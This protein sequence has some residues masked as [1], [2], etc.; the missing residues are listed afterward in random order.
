MRRIYPSFFYDFRCKAQNC[1]HTC[2]RGWDVEIDEASFQSYRDEPGAFGERLRAAI[3]TQDGVHFFRLRDDGRCPMLLD[4]G[5]C[6][7]IVNLG[8]DRLCDIC[9]LHPRFYEEIGDTEL[10]GLGLSC[11]AAAELLLARPL[12]F[13]I[14]EEQE[15]EK[16]KETDFRRLLDRLGLDFPTELLAFSPELTAEELDVLKNALYDDDPFDGEW[17]AKVG[18]LALPAGKDKRKTPPDYGD[19]YHYFMYRQ[20]ERLFEGDVSPEIAAAYAGALTRYVYLRD[21]QTPDTVR[22]LTE[23][24]EEVEYSTSQVDRIF[25]YYESR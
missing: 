6:E 23:V 10:A 1:A 7:L 24:S 25:K 22:H 9:Y 8:E 13:T 20:L 5:L 3:G 4:D 16:T 14:E 15:E 2:C 12:R 11:E 17:N 19:V 18:A 21:L